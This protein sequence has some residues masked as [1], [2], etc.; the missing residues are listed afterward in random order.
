MTVALSFPNGYIPLLSVPSIAMISLLR[1][2]E[3]ISRNLS[4]RSFHRNTL[5][6]MQFIISSLADAS[7][8]VVLRE[9]LVSL[10]EK[11]SLTPMVAGVLTVVA[12][13]LERT[14]PR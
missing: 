10:A 4:W 6:M 5:M 12:L 2:F 7:S 14:T 1:I 11:L 3:K 13:S 8:L 9:T